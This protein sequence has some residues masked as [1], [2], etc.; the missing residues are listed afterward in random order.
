MKKFN[1][2]AKILTVTGL[3]MVFA[4]LYVMVI[5][6]N[7]NHLVIQIKS[8]DFSGIEHS[9]IVSEEELHN[10]YKNI[11][12]DTEWLYIDI[13]GDG[14][15]DLIWQVKNEQTIGKQVIGIFDIGENGKCVLW[16]VMDNGEFYFL[17]DKGDLV[18][19]S[20]YLGLY[21]YKSYRK[22]ECDTLWNKKMVKELCAYNIT[23]ID[24]I[25]YWMDEHDHSGMTEDGIYFV[26]IDNGVERMISRD[27]FIEAF[28]EM[29]QY[30]ILENDAELFWML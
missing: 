4:W 21:G 6:N 1:V 13:N 3:I 12:Q 18:Y 28:E 23:D 20:Q 17:T 25:L 2:K 15:K 10:T 30:N 5:N 8:G 29:T 27:E 22:Y 14:V 16:D 26:L 9:E 24:N 11:A 19:Y 7:E